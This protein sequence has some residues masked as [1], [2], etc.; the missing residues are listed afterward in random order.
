MSPCWSSLSADVSTLPQ[1]GQLSHL[2]LLRAEAGNR[3]QQAGFKPTAQIPREFPEAPQPLGPKT[4]FGGGSLGLGVSS[5]GA[6]A[7]VQGSA[8]DSRCP[9]V[10]MPSLPARARPL[11]SLPSS[12]PPPLPPPLRAEWAP[13]SRPHP[14]LGS[15]WDRLKPQTALKGQR[16]DGRPE[17][18]GGQGPTPDTWGV[19][20]G[21]APDSVQ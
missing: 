1:T 8:S 19:G 16:Q 17:A 12:S 21:G 5:E 13:C 20:V 7:G 3:A 6:E 10:L 2:T 4:W 14:P 9:S 15:L 18:E 11:L